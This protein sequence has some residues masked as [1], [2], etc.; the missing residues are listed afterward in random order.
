VLAKEIPARV[1]AM[2]KELMAQEEQIVALRSEVALARPAVLVSKVCAPVL[3]KLY[4]THQ[5]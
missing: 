1:T 4:L 3:G 2:Q 5:R